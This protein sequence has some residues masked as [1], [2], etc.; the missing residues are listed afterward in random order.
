MLTI[1]IRLDVVDDILAL[2]RKHDTVMW[3]HRF[4]TQYGSMIIQGK[5]YW[6]CHAH[7]VRRAC[8]EPSPSAKDAPEKKTP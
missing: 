6:F 2:D 5:Y 1:G 8:L 3:Q 4:A 7:Q